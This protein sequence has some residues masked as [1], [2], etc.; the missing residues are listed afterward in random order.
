[1]MLAIDGAHA[2]TRPEPSPPERQERQRAK[3]KEAKGFRIYLVDKDR[4]IHL[5]SWHQIQDDKGLA[6]ALL[7][8]KDAGLIPEEK[9]RLCAHRGWCFLDMESRDRDISHHKNK[10]WICFTVLNTYMTWPTNNMAKGQEARRNGLKPL[11]L[12]F[13]INNVSAVISGIKRM[14]PRSKEAEDQIATVVRYLSNHRERMNYGAAR[15]AGYHIGSGAIE[16]AN[17]FIRS[18]SAQTFRG[19]VV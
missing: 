6:E 19:L 15:R 11:S 16:S 4:I 12:V 10:S 14:K 2:P 18:C 9:I 3:Y 8:I 5:I 7:T 13:S 17:K 1:M